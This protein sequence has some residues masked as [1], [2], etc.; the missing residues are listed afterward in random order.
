MI[1]FGTV[2]MLLFCLY[3]GAVVAAE[4]EKLSDALQQLAAESEAVV[5][6]RV[7]SVSAQP[8]KGGGAFALWIVRSIKGRLRGGRDII[9]I[10]QKDLPGGDL[11]PQL[12][13]LFLQR[14]QNGDWHTRLGA[15]ND[16]L[17]KLADLRAPVLLSTLHFL[18]NHGEPPDFP[19]PI[20]DGEIKGWMEQAANG[21]R[22]GSME[23]FTKLAAQGPYIIPKL[24]DYE[25]QSERSISAAARTLLP[26]V[27]SGPPVNG[28]RLGL[29]PAAV[30]FHD[31]D[32]R[33]ITAVFANITSVDTTM[34]TGMTLTGESVRAITAYDI[35]KTDGKGHPIGSPLP[36]V[37][38]APDVAAENQK[39]VQMPIRHAIPAISVYPSD[40]DLSLECKKDAGKNSIRLNFPQGYVELPGFGTYAVRAHFDC[41]GPRLDQQRLI[42]EH[43]WGGGQ[44]VSNDS[45]ITISENKLPEEH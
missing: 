19:E 1:R 3:A 13:L 24:Q 29:R 23:G 21:S 33:E 37:L 9:W 31:G 6:A 10:A 39:S 12:W 8:R 16:G 40:V 7:N 18:G 28:L 22:T 27:T 25:S 14:G 35:W 45:L 26:L 44:L 38:T 2:L 15:N 17:V 32:R 41:P 36:T 43:Y 20:D 34:V 4:P 30:E 42:D 5:V 11:N